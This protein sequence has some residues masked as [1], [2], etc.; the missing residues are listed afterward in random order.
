MGDWSLQFS[1]VITECCGLF[2]GGDDEL[3]VVPGL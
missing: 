3:N 1:F 2:R